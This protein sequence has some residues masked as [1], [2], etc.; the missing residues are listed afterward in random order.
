MNSVDASL[1]A[2]RISASF[3]VLS[4]L[5]VMVTHDTIGW[6]TIALVWLGHV[7]VT[8]AELFQSAA[9]WGF[10][11]ELSDPDRRGEYQGAAQLGRTL[12]SVW[13]PAVYTY[14]AMEWGTPGWLM[15]A[16]HRRAR[17]P[18]HGPVGACRRALPA[19]G[20]G[21]AGLR[22]PCLNHCL[23]PP[24]PP[25]RNGSPAPAP[26]PCPQPSR[27]CSPAPAS[28][29]TS[30][31]RCGGRP[32]LALVV[33]LALQVAVNYANDYSDG[34]RGTDDDRVGP[35][36]LVGSGVASPA[37]VKRAAFAAFGV[38]GVAGLALAAT[39]A[40]WLL[41]RRASSASSP[42][43]S[44]PAA[45][46][47]TATSG[48]ARS[49]SSSSS[50][51]SPC[52]GTTYVQT[53]TCELAALA[54][55]VAIGALACAILV[56]NNLRDIPTDTVAGKRTLAVVLGDKRTRYLY[57]VL[58]ARR[59]GRGR[60]AGAATTWWA[61]LG[62]GFAATA[63]PGRPD[64]ARRGAG[65]GP[66]PGAPADRPGRAGPGPGSSSACSS[67]AAKLCGPARY[68][69]TYAGRMSDS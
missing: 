23:N 68:G 61:L 49:W 69:P 50:G 36:R 31:T 65:P 22:R 29:R 40:W 4:C 26:A 12:G 19:A 56:A 60:A 43:G 58:V 55:A 13:A 35:L 18:G 8:G 2:A 67:V 42:P 47:P 20:R 64:R 15:I 59:A 39:T 62:L 21:A 28:R 38:A 57:V 17:D 1:R 66:D 9:S 3:F 34:I 33:S 11:S 5:I 14:L 16:R 10:K 7:T 27:P 46:G 30:T 6:V 48:S 51:W 52:V 44:T 32:L 54:A 24:W 45:R 25:A 63:V 41:A 53:E 37:A